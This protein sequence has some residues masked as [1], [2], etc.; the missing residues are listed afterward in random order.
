MPLPLLSALL[1]TLF[2]RFQPP[3]VSL[4][5][6]PTTTTVAAGVRSALVIDLGWSETVVT[7]VYDYREIG[8][9]RTIRGGRMLVERIH[10]LI[11]RC[12]AEEGGKSYDEGAESHEYAVSFEECDDLA[13]RLAWCKPVKKSS[14]S[15]QTETALPTVQE[16]EETDMPGSFP[17]DAARGSPIPL[18][19]TRPPV[20]IHP[21]FDQ[22]S[23]P[24]ES[25]FFDPQRPHSE[26]DDEELPVH[27][28]IYRSLLQLPLDVRAICMSRI[29]FTGRC[30]DVLGLRGRIFDEVSQLVRERG[31]SGVTG[32]A[33]EQ[34]KDN[35]RLKRRGSRQASNGPS[36]VDSQPGVGEE[37]EV[38]HDA[39]NASQEKD[40]I[41]EQLRKAGRTSPGAHGEL[42]CVESLGAWSGGSLLA[43]L[44]V[45]AI[46]AIDRDSWLQQG[47]A[48]A[49]RP[50]EVDFKTQQRQSMGAG[51]L[52]RSAS[53]GS[54]WTLGI[55]GAL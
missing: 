49:S 36:G 12:I 6:S 51:G 19:S 33:V 1:D 32:K 40:P 54:N 17:Q 27:L 20:T 30:S 26:F 9:N 15:H 21:T 22:W 31:W 50:S 52:M 25:T 14:T 11:K 8:C 38:W 45:P 47:L 53:A 39:A 34:L 10:K 35:P 5:S 44:K 37:D 46:A 23:E 43:Q 29:V 7:A 41:E 55:W 48:G 13:T 28:L 24:C 16:Q 2:S 18:R 42:R 3:T 4:F